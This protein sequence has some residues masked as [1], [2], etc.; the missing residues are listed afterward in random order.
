MAPFVWPCLIIAG[1][2]R[3]PPH[4]SAEDQPWLR[5]AQ[6]SLCLGSRDQWQRQ[7]WQGLRFLVVQLF[8]S[9]VEGRMYIY[10]LH[11]YFFGRDYNFVSYFGKCRVFVLSHMMAACAGAWISPRDE[12]KDSNQST[13]GIG[14]Y[15]RHVTLL[16]LTHSFLL[17]LP[18]GSL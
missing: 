14:I 3:R 2:I 9:Q 10:K 18:S 7:T 6:P 5:G 13:P 15:R 16:P 11:D 4:S 12:Q 17:L 1:I 8:A